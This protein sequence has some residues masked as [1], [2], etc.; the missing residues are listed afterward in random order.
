M[1]LKQY[2]LTGGARTGK[3][4]IILALEWLGENILHEV[5]IDYIALQQARGVEE[6]W[7]EEDFQDQILKM[8]YRREKLFA[9]MEGDR[10]F[11][12]RSLLD[13]WAYYL[14]DGKEPSANMRKTIEEVRREKPFS[15]VFL[16][17]NFGD[18]AVTCERRENLEESIVLENI[19]KQNY[20]S[21]GFDI[22]R[23]ATESLEERVKEILRHVEE[24]K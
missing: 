9:K 11:L 10:V 15:K 16:I 12:D 23:I 24:D 13:G 14:K 8:Q 1:A 19:Q 17:E 21:L 2:V 4:S 6:P 7:L 22:I 5:A 18:N 3:T 20:L